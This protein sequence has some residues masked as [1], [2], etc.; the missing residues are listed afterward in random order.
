MNTSVLYAL[1]SMFFAGL[2]SILAKY[3]LKEVSGDVALIIRTVIIVIIV[4]LNVLMFDSVSAL[5]NISRYSYTFL[6]LS[7]ITTSFSWIFYYKAIK[8]G[9]VSEVAIIDKGS[10]V[11]T[12]LLSFLIL[13]EPFTPRVAIGGACVLCG[14]IIMAFK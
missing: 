10:I 4:W 11:I 1:I 9:N 7:G 8:I 3:G 14:I 2:T 5:K 13:K 6:I 12:L